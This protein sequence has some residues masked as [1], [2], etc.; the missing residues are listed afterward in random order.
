MPRLRDEHPLPEGYESWSPRMGRGGK[1]FAWVIL[2][3]IG[4]GTALMAWEGFGRWW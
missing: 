2:I 3:V 1:L 4:L